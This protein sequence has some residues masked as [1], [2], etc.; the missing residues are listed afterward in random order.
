M[1]DTDSNSMPQGRWQSSLGATTAA[2]AR[3]ADETAASHRQSIKDLGSVEFC[4][5][6]S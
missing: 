5:P 1:S 4:R 2:R 3:R 6:R